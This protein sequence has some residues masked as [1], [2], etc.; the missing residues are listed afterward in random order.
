MIWNTSTSS[1]ESHSILERDTLV[2][3]GS[4]APL[5]TSVGQQNNNDDKCTIHAGYDIRYFSFY[6][7]FSDG[8]KLKK[9]GM[10]E[11]EEE[12]DEFLQTDRLHCPG[13]LFDKHTLVGLYKHKLT[14]S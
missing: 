5:C 7:T 11:T 12:E 8:A 3:R 6:C 4:T 2:S 1:Y 13:G 10:M 14:E 9:T